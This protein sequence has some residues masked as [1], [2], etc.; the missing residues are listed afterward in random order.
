MKTL[1]RLLP[2]FAILVGVANAAPSITAPT[3]STEDY[4]LI[5]GAVIVALGVF[6]GIRKAIGLMSR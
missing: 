4:V 3:I 5:A 1:F 6:W 2:V